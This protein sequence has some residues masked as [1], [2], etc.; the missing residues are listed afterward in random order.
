MRR[1]TFNAWMALRRE[2]PRVLNFTGVSASSIESTPIDV[3]QTANRP[4]P[5][6]LIGPVC[7]VRSV[8]RPVDE[9]AEADRWRNI[10]PQELTVRRSLND[11]SRYRRIDLPFGRH[12]LGR[13]SG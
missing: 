7:E 3:A 1:R 6:P 2:L 8:A 12:L 10:P 4:Q 11:P 9:S 5:A 13:V